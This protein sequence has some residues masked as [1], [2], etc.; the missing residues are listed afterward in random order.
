MIRILEGIGKIS[1]LWWGWRLG[2]QPPRSICIDCG[3]TGLTTDVFASLLS[4]HVQGKWFTGAG[5]CIDC[6]NGIERQV[7]VKQAKKE[8]A[9][10]DYRQWLFDEGR[11]VPALDFSWCIDYKEHVDA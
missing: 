10:D 4:N 7:T 2:V 8:A 3:K 11:L 5:T 6:H 9:K 1:R